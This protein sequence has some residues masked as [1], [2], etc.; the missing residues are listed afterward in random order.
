LWQANANA[1]LAQAG[2]AVTILPA[3][4][5]Y[6][7]GRSHGHAVPRGVVAAEPL[8]RAGVTCSLATNNVLNPFTPYGDG[9]LMRMANL[10]ANVTHVSRP[11]ELAG[12]LDMVTGDAARL[13]RLPGYGIAVGHDADLVAI[14]A[15]SAADAVATVALPLWGMKRGRMSFTRARPVLHRP[16]APSSQTLPLGP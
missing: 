2:V 4:D 11:A 14:D 16:F 3:T 8:R 1:E 9:S 13:M 15:G 7:M 10:L 6:L 12:C 5:L